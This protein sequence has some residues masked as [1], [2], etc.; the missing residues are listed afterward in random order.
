MKGIL[1]QSDISTRVNL[2]VEQSHQSSNK[3]AKEVG[4]DTSNFSRKLKGS[5]PW[6]I[7]DVNKIS[8]NLNVR[9]SWL[10]DGTGEMFKA[11]EE[12][13]D[14]IPVTTSKNK[15]NGIPLI[16]THAMAGVLSVDSIPINEWD[17]EDRYIIPAFKKSDFCIRV[18][19]DSMQPRYNTG[20]IIACTRVPLSNLW[21]QWG[22][23]YV[24]DTR[25]G[26]LVKHIEKGRDDKH[27]TLVS[28]NPSYKP[29]EIPV[30][31]IFGIAIV[32]GLIRVE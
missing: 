29:F 22:K 12:M 20:D 27:I 26:A 8:T 16:P 10:V 21:F 23:V 24:L 13:L 2:L 18:E 31:E 7:N 1:N 15:D 30:S 19:G 4:I 3:F 5:L 9:K 17:I 28:D 32:N 25:Q 6:T 11:P 14:N